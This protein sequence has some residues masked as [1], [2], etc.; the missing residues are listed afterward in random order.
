MQRMFSTHLSPKCRPQYIVGYGEVAPHILSI[1][2]Y[3]QSDLIGMGVREG[4]DLVTHLRT[5]A[6]YRV[7]IGAHCPVLTVRGTL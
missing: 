7:V 4:N 2:K 6:A 5:T 3:Y 1:A